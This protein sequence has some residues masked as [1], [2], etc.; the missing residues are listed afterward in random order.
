MNYRNDMASG[1]FPGAAD[2]HNQRLVDDIVGSLPDD[3]F[4]NL[5]TLDFD[6]LTREGET[7]SG[8]GQGA[9]VRSAAACPCCGQTL[10]AV[11]LALAAI[12]AWVVIKKIVEN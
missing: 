4:A 6:S 9:P 3:R 1:L 2:T 10:A 11:V 8:P 12:G 7:L 5:E